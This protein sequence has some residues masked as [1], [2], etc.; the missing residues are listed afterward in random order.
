MNAGGA[1]RFCGDT[2]L[3]ECIKAYRRLHSVGS[4]LFS[5][6]N[7]RELPFYAEDDF[8]SV[9]ILIDFLTVISY[10]LANCY[11]DPLITNSQ[12]IVP[13]FIADYYQN[14]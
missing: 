11:Y 2:L 8:Y 3:A 10:S 5:V 12:I 13:L 7:A 14:I 6:T 4:S 1:N 9:F